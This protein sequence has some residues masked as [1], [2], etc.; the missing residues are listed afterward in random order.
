M[1]HAKWNREVNAVMS[2]GVDRVQAIRTVDQSHPGLRQEMIREANEQRGRP[3]PTL[4][5]KAE[6][7]S[8]YSTPAASA[9]SQTKAFSNSPNS[10]SKREQWECIIAE[11]LQ[12]GLSLSQA[13]SEAAKKYPNLRESMIEEAN[14]KRE[15]TYARAN[16]Y[17]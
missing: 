10:L 3:V 8:W 4:D 6:V 9:A 11:Y 13:T 15:G 17:R 1:F 7:D 16:H 2:R 12:Q 14:Q 5:V